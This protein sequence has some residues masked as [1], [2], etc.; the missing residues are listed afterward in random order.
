M[1]IYY[2]NGQFNSPPPPGTAI[3]GGTSAEGTLLSTIYLS[4]LVSDINTSS[5]SVFVR[6]PEGETHY[7]R[8]TRSSDQQYRWGNDVGEII[9]DN[10]DVNYVTPSNLSA[11]TDRIYKGSSSLRVVDNG[12][13]SGEIKMK[14]VG[15]N[16]VTL[17]SNGFETEP[18]RSHS[19][20]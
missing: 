9:L 12:T 6:V 19:I 3:L 20:K 5:T 17:N 18:L 13:G 16:K 1:K 4:N 8:W 14:I 15:N 2:K 7:L 11:F 10:F